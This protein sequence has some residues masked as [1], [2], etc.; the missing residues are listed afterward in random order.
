M[1]SAEVGR[2]I[3]PSSRLRYRLLALPAEELCQSARGFRQVRQRG[4]TFP[5]PPPGLHSARELSTALSEL[6]DELLLSS[7]PVGRRA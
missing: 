4:E 1:A 3:P 7:D 2:A 6:A 5:S